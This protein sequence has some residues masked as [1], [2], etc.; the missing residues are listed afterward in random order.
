MK[1]VQVVNTIVTAVGT[2]TNVNTFDDSIPTTA[3]LTTD[4]MTL[5]ITPKS[6]LNKLKIEIVCNI[7]RTAG[8]GQSTCALFQDSIANAIAAVGWGDSSAYMI[9]IVFTHYMVSGTT[10]SSTFKVRAGSNNGGT[11]TF[12]GIESSRRFGGVM[13]SS[14][15]I[16]EYEG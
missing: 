1:V 7:E 13:A 6:A 16:T 3:E 11:I 5:T 10:N 9:P 8:I 12:N 14:I 15:T 4:L 2:S